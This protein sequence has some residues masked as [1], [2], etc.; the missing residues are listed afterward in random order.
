MQMKQQGI[1]LQNIQTA[2]AALCK[3]QTKLPPKWAE[4]LHTHFSKEDIQMAKKHMK[5]SS[6][7]LITREMQIKTIVMYHLTPVRQAIIIKPTNNTCWRGCREKG[8]LLYCWRECNLV[9]SLQRRVE[10]LKL[11]LL[12]DS[13]ISFLGIYLEKSMTQR[14]GGGDLVAKLC[15]TLGTTWTVA[16]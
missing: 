12:Y 16:H 13:E 3:S 7:S 9:Q 10:R 6:I 5:R 2:H 14:D 4:D 11:V 8:T 1:N 15:L